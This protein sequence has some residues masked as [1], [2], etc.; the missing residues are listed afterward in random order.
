MLGSHYSRQ[1]SVCLPDGFFFLLKV[2]SN[3]KIVMVDAHSVSF[4][5]GNMNPKL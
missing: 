4:G 1:V 3:K 2:L 5:C